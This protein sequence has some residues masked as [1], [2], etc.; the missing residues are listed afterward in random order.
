MRL[1]YTCE[2][3]KEIEQYRQAGHKGR[4]A[5]LPERKAGPTALCVNGP[6]RKLKTFAAGLQSQKMAARLRI[7]SITGRI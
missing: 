2:G 4:S 6:P 1:R 5:S 7:I 3:A